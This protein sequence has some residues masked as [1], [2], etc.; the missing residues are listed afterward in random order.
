MCGKTSLETPPGPTIY[1]NY[2]QRPQATYHF[3]TVLRSQTEPGAVISSARQIVRRLDSNLPPDFSTFPQVLSNSLKARRFNLT[4]V[5]IFAAAACTGPGGTLRGDGLCS[6]PEDRRVWVAN[7]VG[8][9]SGQHPAPGAGA[10]N[11]NCDDRRGDR[12]GG[13][14]GAHS[15][16]AVAAVRIERD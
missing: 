16:P 7:S 11:R 15:N 8:G 14:A 6:H 2:R 1:V 12:T 9:I 3:T 5:G 13:S 10:G 4:L